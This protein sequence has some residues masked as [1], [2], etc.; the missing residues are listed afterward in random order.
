MQL[1]SYLFN[2]KR[3]KF[4]GPNINDRI[5]HEDS[6]I[7]YAKKLK[8]KIVYIS[9]GTL[10]NK[11]IE[12][13]KDCINYFK[14]KDEYF[15]FMSIG[16]NGDISQFSPFPSNF[17]IRTTLPQLEILK[18]AY[19]F[20]T[21]SGMNG[22]SEAILN[23][24]PMISSPQQSEQF[25]NATRLLEVCN[26]YLL[27]KNNQNYSGIETAMNYTISN[28]S[29]IKSKIKEIKLSFDNSI[30]TSGAAQEVLKVVS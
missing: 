6:V 21:H 4:I 2:K 19:L 3:Y 29:F 7:R 5:S 1:H 15:V 23:Q 22:I 11:N 14:D 28:Y 27:D 18:S 12:F 8:K 26:C 24:V 10:F 9:L 16:R 30:G 17:Y 13:F 25:L 20:I